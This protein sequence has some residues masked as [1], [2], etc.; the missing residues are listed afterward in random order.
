[1]F[2]EK[3]KEEKCEICGY[4]ENLE[5]HHINGDPTDNRLENLQILCPNCH[6]KTENFR[7]KNKSKG[8]T[9]TPA[10][11]LFLT[12]EQ[13]IEREK[14]RLEKK[15][16]QERKKYKE[17]HPDVKERTNIIVTCPVCGTQFR[18]TTK[19]VKYCSDEC[20]RQGQA[21]ITKRPS[22]MDLISS[23]KQHR[24]FTA[25]GKYYNVTDNAIRK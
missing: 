8:R 14:D 3:L 25:V 19:R 15:R 18:Q 2:K 5:L 21:E 13:I 9:H 12:E 11:D 7:G 1:M 22:F 17:T 6:A 4:T 24:N 23:L 20:K 10:Q 16:I